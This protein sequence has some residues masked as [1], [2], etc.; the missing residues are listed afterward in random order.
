MKDSIEEAK[1]GKK[2]AK[3]AITYVNEANKA[4]INL[5]AKISTSAQT[6]SE[7]ANK[8]NQLA[9]EADPS[10]RGFRCYKRDS[11]SN[12][13]TCVECCNRRSTYRRTW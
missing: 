3:E 7:M 5:N 1:T 9:K 13:P 8:I 4:M 2:N 10:K 11:R 6:E 12:K